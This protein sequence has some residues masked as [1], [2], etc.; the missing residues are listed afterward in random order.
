MLSICV[1]AFFLVL[2]S[3]RLIRARA[4]S[5]CAVI[6]AAPKRQCAHFSFMWKVSIVSKRE[7]KKNTHMIEQRL[8]P[9]N[10]SAFFFFFYFFLLLLFFFIRIFLVII[11]SVFAISFS[12]SHC[13]A[14]FVCV[15]RFWVRARFRHL[16]EFS[17]SVKSKHFIC[18]P[19]SNISGSG[20]LSFRHD[21]WDFITFFRLKKR[22]TFNI[23]YV[24]RWTCGR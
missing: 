9:A 15:N 5:L 6:H 12:L 18:W 20:Y 3:T 24:D 11:S 17:R 19:V 4:R 2:F 10:H 22:S 8:A 23:W 7:K 14:T 1:D 21:I 13:L 16:Y